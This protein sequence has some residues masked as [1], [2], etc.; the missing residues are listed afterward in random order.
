MIID[1]ALKNKISKIKL[2]ILDVD[3]VL[4]DCKLWFDDRGF[5][6]KAFNVQDG[7]GMKCL[8]Q[9]GVSIAIISGRDSKAVTRRFNALGVEHIYQGVQDKLSVFQKLLQILSLTTEQVAY[10]GDDIPDLI[11]MNQIGLP[12]A[13]ANAVPEVIAASAWQTTRCG[14]EGAVR[15][16]CD[17]IISNQKS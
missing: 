13:V 11:V 2:L 10:V 12:I 5:E 17:L 9:A 6:F 8:Q 1:T 3:G 7:Y 15:Q 16:A 14:G 4:T